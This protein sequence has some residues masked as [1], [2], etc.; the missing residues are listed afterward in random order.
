[1]NFP[2]IVPLTNHTG[3]PQYWSKIE[4]SRYLIAVIQIEVIVCIYKSTAAS[5]SAVNCVSKRQN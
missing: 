1:M 2:D 3:L 5:V 4:V